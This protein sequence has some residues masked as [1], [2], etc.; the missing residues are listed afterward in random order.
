[1]IK[2]SSLALA[3]ALCTGSVFAQTSPASKPADKPAAASCESKAVDK[4]GKALSG[5]AKGA[6]IK[7]CEDDAKS[8][9]KAAPAP[10]ASA[11]SAL[12]PS[13]DK[14]AAASCES[15]AIDKNGKALNGA[16]KGSSIKKCEDDSKSA[17]KSASDVASSPQAACETK[18]VDKNGKALSGAAKSSSV[19]KCV[20][21][22]SVK[23]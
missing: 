15:K 9:S 3:L 17:P 21:D 12:K 10:L 5:A 6:S 18:A 20:A 11:T 13:N 23:K 7:K 8:A 2:T 1:M 19:K 4:N 16:A 14:P 22:A